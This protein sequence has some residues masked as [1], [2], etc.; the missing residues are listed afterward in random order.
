MTSRM[1]FRPDD[2]AARAA[3]SPL[4]DDLRS[5]LLVMPR[6]TMVEEHLEMM[7]FEEQLLA[8]PRFVKPRTAMPRPRRAAFVFACVSATVAGCGLSA[9]GALPK[10]LQ[11]ITDTIAHTLGVPEPSHVDPAPHVG[12]GALGKPS[13][14]RVAPGT[15]HTAT[16]PSKSATSTTRPTPHKPAASHQP[17][18]T[19]H[20]TGQKATP[21]PEPLIKRRPVK[22]SKRV[23]PKGPVKKPAVKNNSENTPPGFPIDWRKRAVAAGAQQLKVCAQADAGTATDCPQVATVTGTPQSVQWTLLNDPRTGAAVVA[24]SKVTQD[25]WGNPA[26]TTTVTVYERFQMEA[27]VTAADGTSSFVYSGGIGQATMAWN[28]SAF[29]K[30]SYLSGSAADHLLPGIKIPALVRPADATDTAAVAAAQAAL[31]ADSQLSSDPTQAVTVAFDPEIGTFTVT[32]S[33]VVTSEAGTPGHTF[34]AAL[35]YDGSAFRV[36]GITGS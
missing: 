10:P 31:P 8:T 25:Q 29:V 12:N 9:A 27:T 24:Q 16:S 21:P 34:T 26:R 3:V 4:L 6:E 18:R 11:R 1:P 20:P 33:Y 23:H 32:G 30:V 36:L 19:T 14:P 2:D 7:A 22:P 17:P 35:F 5:E 15:H 28:G 13:T